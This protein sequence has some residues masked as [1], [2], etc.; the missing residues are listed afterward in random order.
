TITLDTNT[1]TVEDN[2]GGIDEKI[3]HKV[4]EPYFTTKVSN[5]GIGLYMS[6]MIIERNMEGKLSV[7]STD[8]GARFSLIFT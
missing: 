1:V 4:F 3:L 7:V 8:K 5:S 6:K 2:G